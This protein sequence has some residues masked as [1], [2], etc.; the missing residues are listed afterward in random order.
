MAKLIIALLV[1]L[2][3]LPLAPHV[4]AQTLPTGLPNRFAFG[5]EAGS[6]DTWQQQSGIAWDYRWQET[7]WFKEPVRLPAG[8]RL[9]VAGWPDV[10]IFE[11]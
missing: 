10:D 5:L 6:G 1:V 8:A 3:R 2:F 7:Y 11:H 9:D 4:S